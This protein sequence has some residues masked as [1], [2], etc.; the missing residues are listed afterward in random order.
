MDFPRLDYDPEKWMC[1]YCGRVGFKNR[2]DLSRHML[3]HSGKTYVCKT[4]GAEFPNITGMRTHMKNTCFGIR[5]C[6]TCGRK[7]FK[8][9]R[10]YFNHMSEHDPKYAYRSKR[11]EL[12]TK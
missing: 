4:C 5:V 3:M 9:E 1:E 2:A 7:G 11:D 12:D 10:D 8:N 6:T